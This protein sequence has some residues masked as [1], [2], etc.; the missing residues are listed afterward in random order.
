MGFLAYKGG[1]GDEDLRESRE[2]QGRAGR[3]ERFK[4]WLSG[5]VEA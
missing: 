5:C 2:G 3:G 1:G 4:G